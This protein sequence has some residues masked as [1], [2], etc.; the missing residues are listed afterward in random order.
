MT[1]NLAERTVKPF[2]IDRKPA[3]NTDQG[4]KGRKGPDISQV[5]PETPVHGV[6]DHAGSPVNPGQLGIC[7]GFRE[8]KLREPQRKPGVFK[9]GMGTGTEYVSQY[10]RNI[11]QIP[12][13]DKISP[14]TGMD[15]FR[16]EDHNI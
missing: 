8:Y 3:V 1:N 4:N 2:V 12:I 6:G 5:I 16:G 15:I 14:Q 13:F 9:K 11:D 10:G 7:K